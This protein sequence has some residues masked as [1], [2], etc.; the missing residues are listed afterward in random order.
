M[1]LDI[2]AIGVHPD[3]V[4]LSCS[5]TLIKHIELGYK[6]GIC[7]LTRG[8]LGT[9]GT[10]ELRIQ[11]A[12]D[13]GHFMGVEVRENLGMPDGF[14]SGTEEETLEVIRIIRKYQPD[15]VLANAIS[16][17][18]PDHGRAARFIANACFYSGLMKIV[19]QDEGSDQLNWR[20][21][22]VYHYIQDRNIEADFVVDISPYIDRKMEA[23]MKFKSQFFAEDM[24]GPQTPISSKSFL[25]FIRAKNKA[26]GR[27][28]G[29]DYAEA[30]NVSRNIGIKDLFDIQ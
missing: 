2:L 28:I 25:E 1:K 20:P 24:E 11:E 8:E 9:R 19:T 14:M 6:V 16:D 21:Q 18:H 30:F 26:Y 10:P 17:R 29:V 13:A 12:K 7:D 27:D 15:I 5:G 3:D 22:A 23:I 4:E